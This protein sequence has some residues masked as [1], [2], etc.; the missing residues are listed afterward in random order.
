M[1]DRTDAG[2]AR[3]ADDGL[4]LPLGPRLAAGRDA[5]VFDLGDG[6]ILR[7]HRRGVSA[8]PEAAII[9]QAR[10][11]GYPAPDVSEQRGPDLV[12]ERLIGPTML[13]DLGRR[14]WLLRRHARLLADLHR[15]LA[16]IPPL[17]WLKPFPPEAGPADPPAASSAGAPP[18]DAEG[19]P[20]P[21]RPDA[22]ARRS[23][24][25]G[26]PAACLLHLDLHPDNV[27]LTPRGP[28]V[29]DWSSA[30]RGEVAAAVALTWV[31]VATSEIP[32]PPLERRVVDLL[33][34]LFVA[35]F[36]RH[37]DRPAVLRHLSAVARYRLADGNVRPSESLAVRAL[38]RK[39]GVAP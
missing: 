8:G 15:R 9:R 13:A 28:V 21:G 16:T 2:P 35:E 3:A 38:V 22:A 11:H 32:G 29:I 1:G 25:G 6:R 19:A 27:I 36:L 20:A 14:P 31:I 10:A 12:M 17:D 5:D 24:G 4:D 39:A 26:A 34:R 18:G 7:R 30:R 33:R 23:P 37:V